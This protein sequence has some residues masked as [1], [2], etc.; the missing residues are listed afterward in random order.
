M[1]IVNTVVLDKT[2]TITEGKPRVTD[3]ITKME[4]KEFLKIAGSLEKNSEHPLAEAI[5]EKVKEEKIELKEIEE[6]NSI[7]GRGVKGKIKG[8]YYFGGNLALMKENNIYTESINAEDMLNMG[9]TVL[10]FADQN[11][12]IGIIAV[13]DTIKETSYQGIKELKKKNIDIVMITGDNKVVAEKIARRIGIE[14][15]ISEVLPQDKEKEVT[16]LQSQNKKVAFVGD[17]INDS[18]ALVKADVGIRY[19][20]RNRY[21]NRISRH[22]INEKQ[23]TRCGKSDRFKQS[24]N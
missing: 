12:I 17:G 3:I 8:E 14:K 11:S 16:K 18:P 7:S 22:S 10:Y 1:H 4:E 19:R 23:P 24:C 5:L 20:L 15:V 6:F 9:K 2:G 21:S 13:E